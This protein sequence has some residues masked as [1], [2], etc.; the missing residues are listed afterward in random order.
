MK[1][2]KVK[3]L[4]NKRG[5]IL[6]KCSAS[7][8]IFA[9]LYSTSAIAAD[10]KR[11]TIDMI[12][13]VF[14]STMQQMQQSMQQTQ[15]QTQQAAMMAQLQPQTIPSKFFP[16]CKISQAR[17]N[18][19]KRACDT[20]V[21]SPG[22]LQ[23]IEQLANLGSGY[24]DMYEQLLSPAQNT[25]YPVGL[26][27]LDDAKKG[28]TK[29]LQ[30]RLNSLQA[31]KDKIEKEAQLF[32][33]QNQKI[34]SD[35]DKTHKDLFGSKGSA[36][37]DARTR[38][39][40]K[41]FSSA[42]QNIIGQDA[43]ASASGAGLNGIKVGLQTKNKGAVDYAVNQGKIENDINRQIQTV[44]SQIKSQGIQ[45]WSEDMARGNGSVNLSD[46]KRLNVSPQAER[47]AQ[48]EV[49]R[50]SSK[51]ANIQKEL[52]KIDPDYEIPPM[53]KNFGVDFAEFTKGAEDYFKKQYIN[54]CVTM[55]DKG[56][57]ISPEQILTSLNSGVGG[58]GS[59]ALKNYKAALSNIL[60]SDAFIEDKME[61][62]RQL[63]AKYS[64]SNISITYKDSGSQTIKSTTYDLYR[65]TVNACAN[66]FTQNDTFTTGS[67]KQVSQQKQIKRA[68]EYMNDL[69][70]LE[71]TFAAQIGNQVY[72]ALI[73][74][75]GN[76]EDS[77]TCSTSDVFNQ[78]SE[79]FCM[80]H[81]TSC[82]SKVQQCYKQA[83]AH[84]EKKK[85]E[86]KTMQATYNKNVAALVAREEAYLKQIKAQVLADAEYLNK[87]FPGANYSVP[88][89]LFIKMPL[90][91][92]SKFGV[93][94]AGGGTLDFMQD[95]PNQIQKL[96][97]T[98]QKQS[99]EIEKVIADYI[100][101]QEEA[102]RG[103]KAKWEN[104]GEQCY[105]AAQGYRAAVA[106]QNAKM[107][108][109]QQ[110]QMQAIGA[111]CNKYGQFGDTNPLAGCDD[112]NDYSA[113]GLYEDMSGVVQ[114]I[115]T[116][117]R[118]ATTEYRNACAQFNNE[119]EN[120]TEDED[121]DEERVQKSSLADICRKAGNKTSKVN[122][123][124]L[125]LALSGLP[126]ELSKHEDAIKKY[127]KGGKESALPKDVKKSDYKD[128]VLDS[129]AEL[130]SSGEEQDQDAFNQK[131]AETINGEYP[132]KMKE[133]AEAIVTQYDKAQEPLKAAIGKVKSALNGGKFNPKELSDSIS[134][135]QMKASGQENVVQAAS[136]NYMPKGDSSKSMKDQL[137]ELKDKFSKEKNFCAAH[138]NDALLAAVESCLEDD[139]AE[140]CVKNEWRRNKKNETDATREADRAI[141]SITDSSFDSN[142]KKIGEQTQDIDCQA[143]SENQRGIDHYFQ[144]MQ[145]IGGADFSGQ[146]GFGQ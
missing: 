29:S 111:F 25:A 95:L 112:G 79:N 143:A 21:N 54:D 90:N 93:E 86:I 34:L 91:A 73:N 100:G 5:T 15:M 64:G 6:R 37:I 84:V 140:K 110:E 121:E 46:L 11:S 30:D 8:S 24:A 109:Q 131:L 141:A 133:Q 28:M 27:C 12:D 65:N 16:H 36:D 62:I 69:R 3:K 115:S 7:I 128:E 72:D 88:E 108:Q 51:V 139:K 113:Q 40:S 33:E 146:R 23:G 80:K 74:C 130:Y 35:M 96:K 103:Q 39:Y 63:D 26:Q 2:V 98:L 114:G 71:A 13:Q 66:K 104:F 53:D 10:K 4:N 55:A 18:F 14:N 134:S 126:T 48:T 78:K 17:G 70:D 52:K 136:E 127:L 135:Y 31:L 122:K 60:N 99:G 117:H 82:S 20:G 85:S 77:N 59:I 116:Q 92:E 57:A 118:I 132:K 138:N 137:A 49:A 32:T 38:D 50:F 45:Q 107:Q 145:Q 124:L 19:P 87:Y 101:K 120:G 123:E 81:A 61:Q 97:D 42:C 129:I 43:L 94:L 119:R 68:K 56:V 125:K 76:S 41:Y 83:D 44:K 1:T 47:I 67:G 144:Q 102:M 9:L 142:W 75:S 106:E 105:A 89:G 22:Q 58:K